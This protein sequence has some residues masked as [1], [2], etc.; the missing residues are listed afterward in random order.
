MQVE[1][2]L[3]K[4]DLRY[5]ECPSSLTLASHLNAKQST[6]AE[7][8]SGSSGYSI[9]KHVFY[10]QQKIAWNSISLTCLKFNA[11]R[12]ALNITER[13]QKSLRKDVLNGIQA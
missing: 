10:A 5:E 2:N 12:N 7:K 1:C 13:Q 6:K 8:Q 11:L 3:I 9:Q 4:G